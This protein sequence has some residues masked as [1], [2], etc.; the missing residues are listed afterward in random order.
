M[1]IIIVCMFDE[2]DLFIVIMYIC[3]YIFTDSNYC[4]VLP[5]NYL[6]FFNFYFT[7]EIVFNTT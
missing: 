3:I 2:M 6:S 1:I 4:Y 7:S 5:P